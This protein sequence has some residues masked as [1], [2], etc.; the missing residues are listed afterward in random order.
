MR[1]LNQSAKIIGVGEESLLPGE[2]ITLPDI[3][4]GHPVIKK[5]VTEGRLKIL[6][7]EGNFEGGKGQ[8][9][10]EDSWNDMSI[11][12]LKLYVTENSI[13][14]GKAKSK[15]EML[16]KIREQKGEA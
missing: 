7:E 6:E 9:Q 13:D 10:G 8:K 11:E 12:E 14:V 2:S 1:I 5:Y 15:E 3:Y 4:V 16:K